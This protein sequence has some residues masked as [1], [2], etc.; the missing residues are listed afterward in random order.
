MMI[1]TIPTK[2]RVFFYEGLVG[3]FGYI[4][5]EVDTYW[6]NSWY[7]PFILTLVGLAFIALAVYFSNHPGSCARKKQV[8]SNEQNESINVP[9]QEVY[10][11]KVFVFVNYENKN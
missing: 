5:D 1:L 3:A 9:L 11:G 6:S 10:S 8:N 2:Q 4:T 7:L